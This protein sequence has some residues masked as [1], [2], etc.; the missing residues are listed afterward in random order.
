MTRRRESAPS[1]PRS[2]GRRAVR[3]SLIVTVGGQLEQVIGTFTSFFLRSA[4]AVRW[5]LDPARMGVYSSLRELLD[6]ANWSSLGVGQGA[7][8]AIPVLRAAGREAEARR[9]A[10]IAY[11]AAT[12]LCLLYAGGL[13]I[14][15]WAL[16]AVLAGSALATAWSWGLAA[17][18]GLALLHRYQSFLIAV[19]RSFQEFT[20][21][22]ELAVLDSFVFAGLTVAGLWLAGLWGLW[23]AI[24]LLY[25]FNVAYLH[26]RHPL[27]FRWAW[28]GPAI[29]RL[30]RVGLPILANTVAFGVVLHLAKALILRFVPDGARAVG[31]YSVAL[32]G[33]GWGLDLAGRIAIV[34]YTYFQTTLGRT[35]DPSAVAF[36]A[37][38]TTEAQA[39]LLAAGGAVAYLCGPVFLGAMMPLY[40]PGLPALRPLLPGT[41]LI[42]L[43]WPARQML[44]AVDRPYR[45]ALATLA[46]LVLTAEVG[47]IGGSGWGIVGVAYGMSIG[48]AG[49]FLFTGAAAYVPTLGWRAWLVHLGRLALTL[50]LFATGAVVA[51]RIPLPGPGRWAAFAIRCVILAAW[52]LPPLWIWGRRHEWGG[53]FRP[54]EER[55]A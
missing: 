34:M 45:L 36:Q 8:Q 6:N 48:F 5:G 49:V 43:A 42:G 21:T 32:M 10:D 17:V 13:L 30:M 41:I 7:V 19:L 44:I 2:D 29:A 3:D 4:V 55:G 27:R 31:Y 28:D 26:A 39:P 22:T 53:V 52:G 25:L 50:A 23:G 46:G 18:A 9:V 16:S 54:R 1:A 38:R 20:L 11:T 47:A 40:A 37:V 12:L 35:N 33:T 24:G 14:A 51:D 15:A